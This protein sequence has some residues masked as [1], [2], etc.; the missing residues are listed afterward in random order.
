MKGRV[1]V[2]LLPALHLRHCFGYC[3]RP[4]FRSRYHAPIS[5]LW[6]G[7]F[8][9][10]TILCSHRLVSRDPFLSTPSPL[11][12]SYFTVR[13]C[14]F[15]LDLTM[16]CVYSRTHH[17]AGSGGVSSSHHTQ[18]GTRANKG[19]TR[20]HHVHSL[21]HLTLTHLHTA[22]AQRC[23]IQPSD[24]PGLHPLSACRSLPSH[25]AAHTAPHHA[26]LFEPS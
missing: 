25:Q 1:F 14:S 10:D 11:F 26:L 19:T 16:L 23:P 2:S 5:A 22:R 4:R 17:E 18:P 13:L 9:Y 3:R 21:P 8:T 15:V 20:I 24:S 12:L 6:V 7:T